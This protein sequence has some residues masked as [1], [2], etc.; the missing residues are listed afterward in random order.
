M[1]CLRSWCFLVSIALIFLCLL[2]VFLDDA[3]EYGYAIANLA[4]LAWLLI[5]F[6]YRYL[7]ASK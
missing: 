5:A 6:A 3:M 2:L 1:T 7:Q 4:I